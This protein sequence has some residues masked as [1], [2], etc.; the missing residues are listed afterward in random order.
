MANIKNLQMWNTICAD[1]RIGVSK[2]LFGLCSKVVFKPTNSVINAK[3]LEYSHEEGEHIKRIL[4]SSGEVLT[5]TIE[6]YHPKTTLNGNCL[7][8]IC[9]S[10]DRAFVAIQLLQFSQLNYVP[11]TNVVF[12]EGKDASLVAKLFL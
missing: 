7:V 9:M 11:V 2:T 3:T 5:S 12:F 4:E 6:N 8:E 1:A 10:Q